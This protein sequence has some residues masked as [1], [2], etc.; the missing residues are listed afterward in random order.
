VSAQPQKEP[1]KP[2]PGTSP[3]PVRIS[4]R[5]SRATVRRLSDQDEFRSVCGMRRDLVGPSEDEPLLFHYMRIHDSRKHYH[6][7][8]IEYY[9]VV[10]G[11]GEMEL[12]EEVVPIGAGDMIVVPTGVWHTSRPTTDEEL[13]ILICA[14][15]QG[16]DPG[17]VDSHYE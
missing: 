11:S 13:H 12:N 4:A 17:E 1:T 2:G 16:L 14:L 7:K 8:T 9:Y 3:A 10:S 5:A 6:R 15:P